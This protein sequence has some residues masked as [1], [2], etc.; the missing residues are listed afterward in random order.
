MAHIELRIFQKGFNYAQDGPGNRLVLHLQGCNM[1]C[2]WCSNPEGMAAHSIVC[3]TVPVKDVLD[4]CLRSHPM[5]F[6]GGGVTLTGG[7]MSLQLP[8]VIRLFSQLSE[9]GIHTAVETNATHPHL[10]DIFPHTRLI[11]ADLKHHDNEVHKRFTGVGNQTV[12]Q[13]L[14]RAAASGIP[15][16]VRVPLINGFNAAPQDISGFVTVFEA[17]RQSGDFLVESLRYH[18]YGRDKWAQCGLAY[19]VEDGEVSPEFA[20][21]FDAALTAAGIRVVH[22]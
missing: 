1:R 11:I 22:T 5:F 19:A 20:S 3:R 10:E 14:H 6:D 17:L 16:W 7:E 4:E 12:L 9:A 8:A 18:E 15:L 13:N 21:A 2:P